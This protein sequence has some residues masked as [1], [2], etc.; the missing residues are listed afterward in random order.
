MMIKKMLTTFM[1]ASA[2]GAAGPMASPAHTQDSQSDV[3]EAFAQA[4]DAY[5][6]G[7]WAAAY[8]RL[9]AL[10]D[11]NHHADAARIAL[12][13]HRFGPDLYGGARA[14]TKAQRDHWLRIASQ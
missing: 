14:A 5:Q 12:F 8:Q 10:A 6:Q 7:Q 1:L 13:M 4:M 3:K 9:A 11:R 2:I